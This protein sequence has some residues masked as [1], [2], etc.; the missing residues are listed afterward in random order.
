NQGNMPGVF[1]RPTAF[2]PTFHKHTRTLCGGVQIH[3]RDR[4]AFRPVETGVAVLEACRRAGPTSFAWREPPYEHEAVKPPID[5]LCGSARERTSL[6]RGE[7]V[8][9]LARQWATDVEGFL[10]L[11]QRFLLY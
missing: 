1:F 5:I 6:D 2:E 8:A 10:P 7:S 9:T 4:N 11:R 3:V